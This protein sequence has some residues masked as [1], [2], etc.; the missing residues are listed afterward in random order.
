MIEL[1]TLTPV[2]QARQAFLDGCRPASTGTE[3]VSLIAALGRV[4]AQDVTATSDVPGF[5]RST[6]DGYAI[7]AVDT[8]GAGDGLP[9]YLEIRG[10]VLMGEAPGF[11]LS[12]GEAARIPTG[13]MLPDGAD[14]VAM[15]EH[16]EALSETT[17]GITRPVAPGENTIAAGS[18]IARGEILLRR[19]HR[20]RPQDIGALAGLGYAE[21]Q[22]FRRPA[23]AIIATGD[24]IVPPDIEPGPG[25][26]RDMNTYSLAA[27]VTADGGDPRPLGIIRDEYSRLYAAVRDALGHDLVLILGGSSVGARDATARVIVDL[28]PPG[29]LVHGVAL[30]PGKPT[31]LGLAGT[32]P[33]VGVPGHPVSALVVYDVFLRPAIR[34]L[35][36]EAETSGVQGRG[37]VGGQVQAVLTRNVPS[38]TGRE[39]Y[40]RV[41]IR[42]E[43]DRILADPIPGESAMI[44]TMVRADGLVRVPAGREGLAAGSM[45][46]VMLF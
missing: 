45:V 38:T 41:A 8:F 6:V 17:V 13:G 18:D 20:L 27:A 28:G 42:G 24:E 35:A 26:V 37:R 32:V 22:V 19:G 40:V 3:V 14:A 29:V 46:S 39:E 9:S 31:I 11:R 43:G 15:L 7:R 5:T 44:S 33:V 4:L 12:P 34:R 10:E 2:E 36:G 23:V 21:V 25:Q 16:S 1:M 30:K